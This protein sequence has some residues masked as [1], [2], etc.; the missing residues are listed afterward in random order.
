M[1]YL[2]IFIVFSKLNL[3][4]YSFT[5]D[6]KVDNSKIVVNPYAIFL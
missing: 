1:S 4:E 5:L 6:K 2:F 3:S